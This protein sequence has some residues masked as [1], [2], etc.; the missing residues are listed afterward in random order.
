MG[1]VEDVVDI[2]RQTHLGADVHVSGD[3]GNGAGRQARLARVAIVDAAVVILGHV[4][5]VDVEQRHAAAEALVP[6]LPLG[7]QDCATYCCGG[8]WSLFRSLGTCTE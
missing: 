3:F 2:Q 7:D 1:L 5:L 6:R 8:P 4:A